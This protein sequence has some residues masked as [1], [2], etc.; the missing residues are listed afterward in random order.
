MALSAVSITLGLH[1][2]HSLRVS[3]HKDVCDPYTISEQATSFGRTTKEGEDR[4]TARDGRFAVMD[5][6]RILSLSHIAVAANS[7]LLRIEKFKAKKRNQDGDLKKSFSR[8]IAL[9]T[10]VCASGTSHVGSALRDY[11]F[12]QDANE[13][14]KSSTG[15]SSKRFTLI[16]IGY[17][18]PGEAEYA[19]FL[20]NI[21]LDDGL[22]KEEMEIYFSRSR[23]DCELKDIMKA[24]KITKEEV[25]MEDSSLEKAVITKIAS[26]FVV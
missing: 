24:F 11:A 10:I 1:P 7:A 21:G 17:D 2:G 25:E 19:S 3:I 5:A 15:R 6:R 8:G 20:S 23:D 14:N 9:E 18:C 12:Q 26:K 16:A 22:S 4:A 13:S